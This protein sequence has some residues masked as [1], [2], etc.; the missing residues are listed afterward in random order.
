MVTYFLFL[1][2]N[3][4]AASKLLFCL[5][6]NQTIYPLFKVTS[7]LYFVWPTRLVNLIRTKTKQYH[8]FGRHLCSQSIKPTGLSLV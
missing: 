2:I 6:A 5:S 8:L 1:Y 3:F 7:L 4:M